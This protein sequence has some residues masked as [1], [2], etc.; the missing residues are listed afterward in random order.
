VT[1]EAYGEDLAIE[2]CEHLA[3]LGSISKVCELPGMPSR[4]TAYAWIGGRPGFKAMVDAARDQHADL[5]WDEMK[6]LME[7]EIPIDT[8]GR[9]DNAAVRDKEVR[10]NAMRWRMGKLSKRYADRT[11]ITGKDGAPLLVND[12]MTEERMFEGVRRFAFLLARVGEKNKQPAGPPLLGHEL[13]L[14]PSAGT[15]DRPTKVI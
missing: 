13:A 5:V 14:E 1:Q 11:E 12:E 4:S 6:T 2:F 9:M 8:Q 3:E 7:Q 15:T 10:L